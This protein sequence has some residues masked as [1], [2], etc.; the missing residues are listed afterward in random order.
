MLN[1]VMSLQQVRAVLLVVP[2]WRDRDEGPMELEGEVETTN[3]RTGDL[4]S[5]L[6]KC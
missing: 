3:K 5:E 2:P 4:S 6:R 1:S